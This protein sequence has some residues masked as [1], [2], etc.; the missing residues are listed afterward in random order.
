MTEPKYG[1]GFPPNVSTY[2]ASIDHLIVVVHWFMIALFVGW[3]I[4][5]VYCLVKYRH[6]PGHTASYESSHSR[7]PKILEVGIIL[8]EAFLL[9][10]L[11]FPIWSKY[12]NEFPK[13]SESTRIRIVAQQFVWNIHYPGKDGQ[14][15]KADPKFVS[16][17]NPL[18]IDPSDPVG[19]DDII[20]INQLHFPVNKPVIVY[21]SSKD[22]IHSFFIPVLRV[23]QDTIPG[24]LIPVWFQAKDTG[25]FEIGCAQLC[26][27]GHTLM[28]GFVSIDTPEEYATWMAQQ[29]A[30][31]QPAPVK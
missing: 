26:G 17:S 21:L 22:V 2:G 13:E 14:F 11:S 15:G 5:F 19:K 30:D 6:R 25:Q 29:E 7:L 16:D 18:G 1:W 12:R 4:F 28:R 10:G 8:F 24:M 20:T 3:G 27:V 23:K 31:L 9:I